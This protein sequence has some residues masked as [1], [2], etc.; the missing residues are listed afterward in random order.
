[1]SQPVLVKVYG[2]LKPVS[3]PLRDNISHILAAA[4]PPENASLSCTGDM[5]A[6]SFEGIYFPLGEFLAE[7]RQNADEETK[8]RLDVLD[9]ENWK[10]CRH[11]INGREINTRC[12]GL[13]N[14]LDYSGF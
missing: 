1:M 2:G 13:N 5:C 4:C 11:E 6:I 8:G 14:A 12:N 3:G 7:I 10:L 9:L